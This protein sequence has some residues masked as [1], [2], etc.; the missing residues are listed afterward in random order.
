MYEYETNYINAAGYWM[1]FHA[2]A[3]QMRQE[4]I[5]AGNTENAQKY[6]CWAII[7]VRYGLRVFGL[8]EKI[9]KKAAV[10]P[11]HAKLIM[12]ALEQKN[13][14][15][16]AD[17]LTEALDKLESHMSTQLM[18]AVATLSASNATRRSGK[19][20]PAEKK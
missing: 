7:A 8:S 13:D 19:G 10:D 15:P 9:C 5:A 1:S 20:G 3:V 6:D 14:T 16:A 11:V 4:A 17:D 12:P 18:K 2:S